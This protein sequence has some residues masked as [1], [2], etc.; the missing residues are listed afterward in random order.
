MPAH[1]FVIGLR[2][3]LAPTMTL[4]LRPGIHGGGRSDA[5]GPPGETRLPSDVGTILMA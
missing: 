5:M 4:C 1:Q 2:E 3:W